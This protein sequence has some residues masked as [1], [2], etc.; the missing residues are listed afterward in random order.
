MTNNRNLGPA[1]GGR[2]RSSLRNARVDLPFPRN[3][4]AQRQSFQ[5]RKFRNRQG[6]RGEGVSAFVQKNPVSVAAAYATGQKTSEPKITASR[7]HSRIIHR[8]LV[9]S[10]AGTTAFTIAQTLALNPGIAATFP[11][12]ATQAVGWE[13][14]RFN[15]LDFEYFTRTGSNVPGSIMLVPDYDAGD[16]APLTEQIASAFEDVVEDAPWKDLCCK[17]RP[18][19]MHSMGPKKFVRTGPLPAGQDIK[20]TDVGNLFLATTDGTAV[21]WGKLWV[22]YDIEFFTP[23]LPP[24]GGA[25]LLSQHVKSAAP[26]TANMLGAVPVQQAGSSTIVNIAGEVLTFAL[27]GRFVL[28][29]GVQ[30]TTGTQASLPTL[31]GGG[32]LLTNYFPSGTGQNVAG[33][34]TA[35]MIQQIALDA[36]VGSVITF[37]NTLVAGAGADLVISQVLPSLT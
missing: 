17:L 23:Q 33:S 9:A 27:P 21:S 6:S 29:Y 5:P 12:L 26:T 25:P 8:E 7:G 32:A 30:G 28:A 11:W 35:S 24:A 20:T 1:Q 14:Y 13:Q 31:N 19:A 15:R 22:E 2:G 36:V 34:G 37:T 4:P 3:G 10:I 18:R 16:S